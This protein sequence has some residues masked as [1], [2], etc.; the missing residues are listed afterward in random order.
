MTVAPRRAHARDRVEQILFR[1]R[2]DERVTLRT[3]R[4]ERIEPEVGVLDR[5]PCL[6]A[7]DAGVEGIEELGAQGRGA[8]G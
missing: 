7:L 3:D 4:L 1:V 6:S 5:R 2:G 8:S